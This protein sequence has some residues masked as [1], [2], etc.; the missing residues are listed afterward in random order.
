[1]MYPFDM[2]KKDYKVLYWSTKRL[3]SIYEGDG[4]GVPKC[5]PEIVLYNQENYPTCLAIQGHPEMM[6]KESPI[7]N[8]LNDL[9]D[10]CLEDVR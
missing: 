2:N 6:R 7:I 8:I 4:I 10:K 5:E 1:M 3:S 9:I